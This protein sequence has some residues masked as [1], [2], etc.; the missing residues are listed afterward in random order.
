MA[1]D[2][3]GGTIKERHMALGVPEV[4]DI[5]VNATQILVGSYDVTLR[6]SRQTP[7]PAEEDVQ[8][9]G[10]DRVAGWVRMSHAQAWT[11]A[12][13]VLRLLSDLVRD[14]GCFLVT[15][16]L[17]ERLD[18]RDEYQRLQELADAATRD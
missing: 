15:K 3:Y 14:H 7:Q 8:E 11:A 6:L 17:L 13:L 18:L 12:H 1:D 4:P 9:R 2:N 16:D 10:E 5:Y